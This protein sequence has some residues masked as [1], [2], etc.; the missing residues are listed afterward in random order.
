MNITAISVFVSPIYRPKLRRTYNWITFVPRRT[1]LSVHEKSDHCMMAGNFLYYRYPCS[2]VEC[3]GSM[4][5]YQDI[6]TTSLSSQYQ[7]QSCARLPPERK[8][9]SYQT[10]AKDYDSISPSMT[11]MRDKARWTSY[12]CQTRETQQSCP[13]VKVSPER[14]R[15]N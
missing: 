2:S 5:R 7:T 4:W 15:L 9:I 3:N 6:G 12:P 13:E 10:S 14:G 8:L 1:S 11:N